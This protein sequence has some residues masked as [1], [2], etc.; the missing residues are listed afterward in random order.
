MKLLL[1]LLLGL[2]ANAE[3]PDTDEE[4]GRTTRYFISVGLK[5]CAAEEDEVSTICKSNEYCYGFKDT[6]E[7]HEVIQYGFCANKK[8]KK[9]VSE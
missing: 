6:D 3:T 7:T 1:V 4:R 8:D 2:Q 5:I 9:N